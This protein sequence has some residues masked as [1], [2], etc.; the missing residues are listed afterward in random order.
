MG[1]GVG[2]LKMKS[3]KFGWSD[4]TP[5]GR[6]KQ[7][8]GGREE[9]INQSTGGVCGEVALGLS[10]KEVRENGK[11]F[12]ERKGTLEKQLRKTEAC[13]TGHEC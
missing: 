8:V 7:C 11:D 6:V 4:V 9:G 2:N 12:Q 3:C 1:E 10:R 13:H 5:S